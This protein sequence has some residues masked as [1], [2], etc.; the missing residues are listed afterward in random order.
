MKQ[1]R[2]CRCDFLTEPRHPA[3]VHRYQP[4]YQPEEA[5][6]PISTP[7]PVLVPHSS[8]LVNATITVN[9]ENYY[10]IPFSVDTN[11]MLDVIIIGS[12]TA[13]GGSGNDIIVLLLD[14]IAYTNW[15]NRHQVTAIYNS[16][17]LTTATINIPITISG[18]YHVVFSNRF[19]IISTKTVS[20]TIDLKWTEIEYR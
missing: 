17:Q 13:S 16:G 15:V 6:T 19:S 12:F 5:A 14:D 10:H 3:G 18:T 2:S 9:A 4:Q 8:N 11:V 20:T 1:A 7:R